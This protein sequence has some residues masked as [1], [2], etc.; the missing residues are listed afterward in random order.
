MSSKCHHIYLQVLALQSISH[1]HVQPSLVPLDHGVEHLV[2]LMSTS[3]NHA[4]VTRAGQR[5]VAVVVV[6]VGGVSII[7]SS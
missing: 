3:V 6:C 1:P 7:E 2:L 5:V 4:A